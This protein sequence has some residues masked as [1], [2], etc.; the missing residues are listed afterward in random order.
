M[1]RGIGF[2]G[3]AAAAAVGGVAAFAGWIEPRRLVVREVALELPAVAAGARRRAA[4]VMADL[5][6]GAPH[7]GRTAIANWVERMNAAAP[8]AILLA[9]DFLDAHPVFGGRLAPER[10]AELL[11]ALRAPLGIA[12]VLGNHDWAQAGARMWLALRAGRDPRAGERL[13]GARRAR[14]ALPRRRA[15]RPAQPPARPAEGAERESRAGNRWCCSATTPT[16]S[17]GSRTRSR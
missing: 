11:G 8:D 15:R 16:C 10:V 1:R 5:H 4:G 7:A 3:A 13:G 6:A 14:W 17:R 12:A 9:G 2:A